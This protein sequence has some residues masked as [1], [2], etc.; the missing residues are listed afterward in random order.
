MILVEPK[1]CVVH[2]F[3]YGHEQKI[4]RKINSSLSVFHNKRRQ[5]H[6]NKP[7]FE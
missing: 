3:S 5:I 7:T 6:E 4:T 2:T 1:M